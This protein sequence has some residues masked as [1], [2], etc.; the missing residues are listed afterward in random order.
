MNKRMHRVAIAGSLV[1]AVFVGAALG[2]AI[3]T[4]VTNF[5]MIKG[6]KGKHVAKVSNDGRLLVDGEGGVVGPAGNGY[7]KTFSQTT[8]SGET[9]LASAGVP[10]VRHDDGIITGIS[11][12]VAPSASGPVTVVLRIGQRTLWRGSIPSGGGHLND[13]FEFGLVSTDGFHTLVTNPSSAD[14]RYVVYGEGFGQS[15][16]HAPLIGH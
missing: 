4:A 5:V 14:V 12:D 7:I 2:P 16:I 9:I 1:V 6:P 11:V 13:Q 8:P 10:I 3:A 15:P